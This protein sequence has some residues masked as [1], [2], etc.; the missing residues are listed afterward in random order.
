LLPPIRVDNACMNRLSFP[1]AS[2]TDEVRFQMSLLHLL[3]PGAA[4]S[5]QVAE[6]EGLLPEPGTMTQAR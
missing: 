2:P 4:S 3:Y 6:I 5:T 1:A